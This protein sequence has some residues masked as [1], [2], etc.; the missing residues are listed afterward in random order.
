MPACR[1]ARKF[2]WETSLLKFNN[3][4][5]KKIKYRMGLPCTQALLQLRL[6]C[7]A[8]APYMMQ[9]HWQW[10]R[11]LFVLIDNKMK[12]MNLQFIYIIG[13]FCFVNFTYFCILLSNPMNALFTDL[14]PPVV[15]RTP[16]TDGARYWGAC[17]NNMFSVYKEIREYLIL[18]G[19]LTALTIVWKHHMHM[20]HSKEIK[21]K[22][23][24]TY[25]NRCTQAWSRAQMSSHI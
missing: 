21:A 1:Q 23:V 17:Q 11:C 22:D 6:G 13:L 15:F 8:V 7:K 16:L 19:K 4:T 3:Y 10:K 9:I 24:E 18:W 20:I 14:V 12:V 5:H 25:I 2:Y